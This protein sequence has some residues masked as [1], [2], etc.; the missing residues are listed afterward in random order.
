[1]DVRLLVLKVEQIADPKVLE[2]V[3]SKADWMVDPMVDRSDN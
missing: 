1:M 3:E 2:L